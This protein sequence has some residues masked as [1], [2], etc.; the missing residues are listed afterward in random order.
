MLVTKNISDCDNFDANSYETPDRWAAQI[1]KLI[2]PSDRLILE[3]CAGTGQIAKYLPQDRIIHCNEISF[4]RYEAGRCN[5]PHGRWLNEDFLKLNWGYEYDL[6]ISN[7][8]FSKAMEFVGRSLSL[9]NRNNPSARIL[10]LLPINVF[11]SVSRSDALKSLD[12]HIHRVYLIPGRVDYLKEGVPMSKCQKVVNGVPQVK[13]GKPVPT[14]GRHLNDAVWDIRPG[15]K[16]GAIAF[17]D[18][19]V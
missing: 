6:V 2:L 3:P 13:N 11:S 17:L 4:A 7:F 19:V 10:V 8:P 15:K 16:E 5:I 14:S 1:A 9:L 12:C 18:E